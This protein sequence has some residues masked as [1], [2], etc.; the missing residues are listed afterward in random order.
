[1]FFQRLEMEISKL[2]GSVLIKITSNSEN[3][4]RF[5]LYDLIYLVE[6]I[7]NY[8]LINSRTVSFSG[9]DYH[10]LSIASPV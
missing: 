5:G 8:G 7:S 9:V 4:S 6:I 10:N 1:M 3:V 2:L